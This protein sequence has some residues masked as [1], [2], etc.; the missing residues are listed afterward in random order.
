MTAPQQHPGGAYV[1]AGYELK[2]KKP[3]YKRVWFWL[4]ALVAII[5]IAAVAGGGAS[6]G[7]AD[8]SPAAESS[9]ASSQSGQVDEPEAPAPSPEPPPE[10]DLTPGQQNA[11][12]KAEEY[13]SVSSFSRPGLIEQLEFEGFSNADATFAVD[14]LGV[15]WNEQAAKKAQEY[16]DVSSFSRSGLVEQL[17]FEGFT[18]AEAEYGAAQA[19][20]G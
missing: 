6:S 17:T 4:L 10:P 3:I 20:D 12:S 18:P 16:L 19:Y 1:P 14:R 11:V 5:V 8:S 9:A 13:L 15:D 2:K 7:G